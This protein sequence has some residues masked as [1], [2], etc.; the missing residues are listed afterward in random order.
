MLEP[1]GN[2]VVQKDGKGIPKPIETSSLTKEGWKEKDLENYLRENLIHLIS[3]DLMV[4]SQSRPFQPEADLLA[5]DQ[6]AEL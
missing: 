6:N 5:L 3:G 1:K 2:Y 4:I